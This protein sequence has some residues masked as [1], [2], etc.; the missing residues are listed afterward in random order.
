M[1]ALEGIKVLDLTRALAGPFCTLMLGDHGADVIKIEIPGAG[2]DTRKW[3]PPFVGGESAYFL[4]INRNKRSLTLNFKEEK[5]REIFRKLAKDADVVVENFTPGVMER[6]GLGYEAIK[7]INPGI[8]FCSISGFGQDGPYSSRPAYDQI[9]QGISGLMSITGEPDGEPQK[10]GIAVADIGAGMWGAF[11]VMAALHNR[12][13]QGKGEGQH[14]DIS[15]MDAQVAWLTYQA[16]NFFATGE[17]PKRLGAAHPNLVPYQAF[18][19]QDNKY[20]NLAV[21]SERIWERFCDGMEMP[22]LKDNPD[23]ATNVE[24]AQ[25]RS[26]IVPLLQEI[27]IKHP[28][29]HWVEKLQKVSVPC[30]PINDLADVFSDPQTLHR[31]MYQEI[32]HPTLGKIKQLGIP[33]KFSRTPGALDLPPPLLGEHNQEVLESLGYSAA[34]IAELKAQAVI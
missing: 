3:G 21:G 34:E 7:A 12:S 31:E 9:M 22:E 20:L 11:A 23:Y 18:M 25:N 16:A 4:S 24:R 8:V 32:A 13:H 33:V 19:C 6:F 28:V 2:D 10:V 27:F 26:K 29:N 30:G 1:K 15:M 14:I 5:A 17:A